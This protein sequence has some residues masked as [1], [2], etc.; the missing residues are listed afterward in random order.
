[1]SI[2]VEIRIQGAMDDL[3]RRTY[4]PDQHVAWDLRF[5]DIQY[6]PR[7]D[8]CKPQ[9]FL[10]TTRI[11]FGLQVR[12]TGET[13]GQQALPSGACTTAL[14]FQS[15]DPKSL[16]R[17]GSGYWRYIPEPNA[18]RF[19]TGYNYQVR[20]GLLGRI[21]D[22]M[23][24]R[25]LM[26]WATAWSF[27][28]LRLWIEKGIAPSAS[29]QNSLIHLIAR[30]TLAGVWVYQGAVPKLFGPHADELAMVE[31]GGVSA[32]AAPLVVQA[33]GWIEVAFGL[34]M[35]LFFHSRW[36]L[37]STIVLMVGATIGVAV[38]S[39]QFLHAAFNPV[40]LNVLMIAT[41]VIGLLAG[42]NLPSARRCLRKPSGDE[43]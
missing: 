1:M 14:K 30:L 2:Y 43:K 21:F 32:T 40:S 20:F 41:A 35:L 38:N 28:R 10:Y 11:G 13:E 3:W 42:R 34:T 12:G 8:E 27:D 6:L 7:P 16:I 25:P 33:V 5:T 26:G 39:P 19:L 4:T 24:F 23:F 37:V 9:Q 29:L 22:G 17:E 31:Q 18:I 15:D 36:P